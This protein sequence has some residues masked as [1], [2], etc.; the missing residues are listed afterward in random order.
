MLTDHRVAQ[1]R[2]ARQGRDQRLLARAFG[3]FIA[4]LAKWDWFV[5]VTFRDRDLREEAGGRGDLCREGCFAICKPDPRLERYEPGSRYSRKDGPPVQEAAISRIEKWLREI[6]T[7]ARNP[8]G[9]MIAEEFGRLGGRWHCHAL[10][11]G[12]SHLFRRR[13]W[14]EAY[15]RFGYTRIEPFDPA[16]GAAFYASKHAGR[17]L[18]EIHFGGTLAGIDLSNWHVCP[19]EG[20]GRDVVVSVPLPK[21]FFHMTLPRRHR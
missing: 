8:I 18:G 2:W 11:T 17:S 10:V 21:Q 14:L 1:E 15:R 6:E 3:R 5:T 7:E 4:P 9:W 20:G 12:V 16:R 13:F 19:A